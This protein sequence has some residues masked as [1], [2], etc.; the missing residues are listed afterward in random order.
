VFK[1]DINFFVII[2]V[3]YELRY[4]LDLIIPVKGVYKA[5]KVF[6]YFLGTYTP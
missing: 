1:V 6:K 4:K 3:M 5:Y 2:H